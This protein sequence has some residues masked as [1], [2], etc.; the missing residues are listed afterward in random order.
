M[1]KTKK[2]FRFLTVF[3]LVLTMFVTFCIPASAAGVET[4]YASAVWEPTMYFTGGNLTPTKTMGVSGTLYVTATFT[5][6]D[7]SNYGTPARCVLQL[8]DTSGNVLVQQTGI[9]YTSVTLTVSLAV[10]QGQQIR[11]YTGMYDY[12]TGVARSA[13]VQYC[14]FIS[15]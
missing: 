4:W 11:V 15:T 12:S 10:T 14:H 13:Q 7:T 9:T 8:R 3:A 5:L 2:N 6:T 1:Y